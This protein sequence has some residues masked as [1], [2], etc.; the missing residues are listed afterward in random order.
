MMISES[1]EF[2]SF[3]I[4]W[5]SFGAKLHGRLVTKEEVDAFDAA[6]HDCWQQDVIG[7]KTP[8]AFV[9]A[10]GVHDI[11]ETLRFASKNNLSVSIRS[12][13]GH[14]HLNIKQDALCLDIRALDWT[15]VN[16]QERYIDVGGGFHLRDVDYETGAFGL[17]TPLGALGHTGAG[18][19]FGGGYGI[20]SRQYGLTVDN[21]LEMDVVTADSFQILVSPKINADLFWALMGGGGGYCVVTRFRFKL[22]EIAMPLCGGLMMFHWSKGPEVIE[23]YKHWIDGRRPEY[24]SAHFGMGYGPDGSKCLM[25]LPLVNSSDMAEANEILK[26]FTDLN[27]EINAV[28]PLYYWEFQG[29]LDPILT[30]GNYYDVGAYI[31]DFDLDS[32]VK[33]YNEFE[34]LPEGADKRSAVIFEEVSGKVHDVDPSAFPVKTRAAKVWLT[35]VLAWADEDADK[36]DS[37]VA[38]ARRL[39][40]IGV[41]GQKK[42]V[43]Y[44]LSGEFPTNNAELAAVFGGEHVE[45]LFAIRRKY[46]PNRLFVGNATD[47]KMN[48]YG[49]K[50]TVATPVTSTARLNVEKKDGYSYG[51][52]A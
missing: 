34:N 25:L 47:F 3:E 10:S 38:F 35:A 21:V 1:N 5:C 23:T 37:Y 18:L 48:I 17:A 8:C 2:E 22:Q 20:L 7:R 9:Y 36:R 16:A 13:G 27:P 24:V 30:P 32:M 4:S 51:K 12:K 33:L 49:E 52:A 14:S 15:R 39:R 45:K 11:M 19:V 28:R 31:E 41:S 42:P 46:D 26:P 43:A 6:V 44:S 50:S 40:S 29:Q